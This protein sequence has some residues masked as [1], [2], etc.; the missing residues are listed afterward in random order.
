VLWNSPGAA[1]RGTGRELLAPGPGTG[2][3]AGL[4]MAPPN[5]GTS[6]SGVA[7]CRTAARDTER[8]DTRVPGPAC[9]QLIYVTYAWNPTHILTL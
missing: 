1:R 8:V 9:G 6:T 2:T 3:G 4:G 7:G 5:S